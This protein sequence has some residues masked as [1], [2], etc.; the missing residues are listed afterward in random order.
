LEADGLYGNLTALGNPDYYCQIY[1]VP[2]DTRKQRI[3][4]VLAAVRLSDNASDKVTAYSKG[5]R[6]KLAMARAMVHDPDI[7]ILDEPNS[8]VDSSGQIIL[9]LDQSGKTIFVSSHNLDEVQRICNRTVLIHHGEMR[10]QGEPLQL[11]KEMGS[12]KIII[13]IAGAPK[14]DLFPIID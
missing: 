2:T 9:N 14:E 1:N 10:L 12:D 8:G 11:Q 13:R 7:L 3:R 5:K 4:K 6:Q